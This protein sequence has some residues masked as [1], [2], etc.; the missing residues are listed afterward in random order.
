V[1]TN[2]DMH[3]KL[4]ADP[5]FEAGGVDTGYLTRWLSGAGRG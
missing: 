5:E 1:V 4:L 2:L 3:R